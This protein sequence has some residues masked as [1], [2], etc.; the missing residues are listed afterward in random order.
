[1]NYRLKVASLV[2]GLCAMGSTAVMAATHKTPPW[3]PGPFKVLLE[4]NQNN[5][6]EWA[7]TINNL[8]TMEKVVGMDHAHAEVI[9]W[10]P[11]IKFLLKNS[12][13]AKDIQSLSMYGVQFSACHQTMKA[14]HITKAQLASGVTVVPG[15]IAEIV[16]RHNEGWTEIKE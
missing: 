16:K 3:G 6:A 15:A 14:M 5:H 13:Y 9:A 2:L 12:P 7:I 4:V 11:G 1:M 8:S 10:G